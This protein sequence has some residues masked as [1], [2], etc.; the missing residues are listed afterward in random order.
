MKGTCSNQLQRFAVNMVVHA[1]PSVNRQ[2]RIASVEKR[3]K[4]TGR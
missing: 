3:L 4:N 2:L 1:G